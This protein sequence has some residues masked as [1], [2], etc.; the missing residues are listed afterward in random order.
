MSLIGSRTPVSV[1]Q[2]RELQK[3]ERE[4]NSYRKN[5]V[6]TDTSQMPLALGTHSASYADGG[7]ASWLRHDDVTVATLRRVVIQN[8]L[9][10]L[11]GLAA[12][13]LSLDH[14]HLLAF[15]HVHNLHG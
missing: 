15:H 12:A 5:L 1:R 10:H 4:R 3:R 11:R 2:W 9:R 7:D 14:C 6:S 8:V 13:S